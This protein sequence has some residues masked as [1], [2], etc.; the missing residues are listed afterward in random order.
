MRYLDGS[1][2]LVEYLDS[3][4]EQRFRDT[5]S[6]QSQINNN[7]ERFLQSK[8]DFKLMRTGGVFL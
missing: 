8:S 2:R 5:H 1:Y 3:W 4:T 6:H 7:T